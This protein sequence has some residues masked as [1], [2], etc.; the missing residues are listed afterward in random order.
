MSVSFDHSIYTVV[1]T[2]SSSLLGVFYNYTVVSIQKYTFLT[3]LLQT[4]SPLKTGHV[5]HMS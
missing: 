1:L 3:G 5:T 2:H 4:Q